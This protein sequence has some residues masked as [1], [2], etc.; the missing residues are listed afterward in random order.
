M[1]GSALQRWT[2]WWHEKS[3]E[4]GGG[5]EEGGR[6]APKDRRDADYAR[7]L[8]IAV[9]PA[10]QLGF[11]SFSRIRFCW[12][13]CFTCM[14]AHFSIIPIVGEFHF[15]WKQVFYLHGSSISIELIDYLDI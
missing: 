3:Y 11:A 1:T 9:L 2:L 10:S 7:L 5:L 6:R 15:F 13:R 8:K 12:K 4:K 14:G